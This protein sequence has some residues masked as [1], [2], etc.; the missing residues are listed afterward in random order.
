MRRSGGLTDEEDRP[1]QI[2][3]PMDPQI[4]SYTIAANL[5]VQNEDKQRLLEIETVEER[6]SAR[7]GNVE[8]GAA[9][10]GTCEVDPR[11]FCAAGL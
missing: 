9:V 1:G 3:A 8:R 6:L 7:V 2:V 4:L 11:Y 10:F 5:Q